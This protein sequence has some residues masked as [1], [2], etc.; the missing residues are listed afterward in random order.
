M[1]IY[2]K[3]HKYIIDLPYQVKVALATLV[4]GS[5]SLQAAEEKHQSKED[6][7][8]KAK[9]VMV[10]T[11][12]TYPYAVN[13]NGLAQ[14]N[15]Y[16]LHNN[17]TIDNNNNNKDVADNTKKK[18]D[19]KEKT[20]TGADFGV[21]FT[22]KGKTVTYYYPGDSVVVL[23]GNI[24]NRQNNPGAL[25]YGEFAKNH[26]AI[27]KG[28]RGFAIFPSAEEGIEALKALL[29]SENYRN[30]TIFEAMKRFAPA[31]ENDPKAY[32]DGI[33]KATGIDATKKLYELT[34]DELVLVAHK[35]AVTEGFNRF[36]AVPQFMQEVQ[37][38]R[39]VR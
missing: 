11:R 27:G 31:H 7:K 23:K 1:K 34:K 15:T 16:V 25:K 38:A 2:N 12:I 26:G 19:V 37:H 24:P 14:N 22:S 8:Q 3:V 33:R 9:T 10:D 21:K 13:Y 20:L 4:V 29:Q 32:A 28:A 17:D 5:L 35:I 18:A 36:S 6:A 39:G 30:L